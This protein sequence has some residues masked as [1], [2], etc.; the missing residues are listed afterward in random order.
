MR[1]LTQPA[2]TEAPIESI[3]LANAVAT[4]A[5]EKKAY[6]IVLL[7]MRG[8]VAFTDVFV[9]CSARNKRQVRAVA[10]HVRLTAKHSCKSQ[11]HGIEGLE[12]CRWV[13]VDL[14]G[15]VVHVFEQ[16]LRGF[17]D[18]D[19]LWQDAPQLAVPE[20]EGVASEESGLLF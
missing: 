8:L 15:V 11:P 20:V 2:P 19:G 10:E 12:A 17:Y 16:P 1:Q 7:D 5:M 18:L 9:I 3:D 4:A 14:P 6:D 13:L